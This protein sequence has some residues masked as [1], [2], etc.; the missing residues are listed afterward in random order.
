MEFRSSGAQIS[1]QQQLRK[2]SF[3]RQDFETP[4]FK[5]SPGFLCHLLFPHSIS[6]MFSPSVSWVLL[7]RVWPWNAGCKADPLLS[8]P[9]S[10]LYR[11]LTRTLNT[12]LLVKWKD[13]ILIP[14]HP[15]QST[16]I[17][18][19]TV[20]KGHIWTWWACEAGAGSTLSL[21]ALISRSKVSDH[22][23]AQTVH[24]PEM[25]VLPVPESR[26]ASH[27]IL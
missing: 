23:T 18:W 5:S 13:R 7:W 4:A 26:H 27:I 3:W 11:K 15:S 9:K 10:K 16:D 14:E 24:V 2:Q 22:R 21:W 12:D 25:N 8:R 1:V 19:L 17:H 6:F 20:Q